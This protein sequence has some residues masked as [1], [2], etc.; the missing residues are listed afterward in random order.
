[1]KIFGHVIKEELVF[2][3]NY[4]NY[5]NYCHFQRWYVMMIIKYLELWF[6]IFF[7]DQQVTSPHEKKRNPSESQRSDFLITILWYYDQIWGR[8]YICGCFCVISIWF[9]S[10]FLIFLF[11]RHSG[12]HPPPP[13]DLPTKKTPYFLSEMTREGPGTHRLLSENFEVKREV[14]RT[15][16]DKKNWGHRFILNSPWSQCSASCWRWSGRSQ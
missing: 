16:L 6:W 3:D 10:L 14:F 15:F 7:Y 13:H 5:H 4:H 9:Q 12:R 2:D 11:C 1:M 8:Y